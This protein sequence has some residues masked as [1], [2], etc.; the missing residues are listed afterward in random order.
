M[1]VGLRFYRPLNQNSENTNININLYF[2]WIHPIP[3]WLFI[4]FIQY[5]NKSVEKNK[6]KKM[7]PCLLYLS[8]PPSLPRLSGYPDA[9]GK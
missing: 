5:F 4:R 7:I 8:L 3:N 9:L 6:N 2:K 1:N